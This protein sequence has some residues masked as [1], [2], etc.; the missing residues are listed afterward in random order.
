M[1]AARRYVQSRA[2]HL[3]RARARCWAWRVSAEVQSWLRWSGRYRDRAAD[4]DPARRTS[5]FGNDCPRSRPMQS[6]PTIMAKIAAA[7]SLYAALRPDHRKD[8]FHDGI[9]VIAETRDRLH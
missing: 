1:S 2:P 3:R 9:I 4:N 8:R 7:T 6:F 5:P